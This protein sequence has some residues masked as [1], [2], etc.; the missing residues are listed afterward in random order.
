MGCSG[1]W[2]GSKMCCLRAM[3]GSTT[4]T[5]S[6]RAGECPRAR[7]STER[8]HSSPQLHCIHPCSPLA[9][10]MLQPK[11]PSPAEAPAAVALTFFGKEGTASLPNDAVV[12]E[13][14]W[15]GLQPACTRQR[16]RQSLLPWL[17]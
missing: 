13:K 12:S 9:V 2:Q 8:R 3:R 17:L 5:A 16:P 6:A 4:L 7:A 14:R 15:P 1:L 10:R 11:E